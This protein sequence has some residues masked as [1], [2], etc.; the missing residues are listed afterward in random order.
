[1]PRQAQDRREEETLNTAGRFCR[2]QSLIFSFR[3]RY[4]PFMSTASFKSIQ[5][6]PMDTWEAAL[7][8]PA[9]KAQML[10]EITELMTADTRAGTLTKAQWE[11]SSARWEN[12]YPVVPDFIYE[13]SPEDSFAALALATGTPVLVRKR[14]IITASFSH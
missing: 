9:V 6:E 8:D 11:P 1:M 4:H 3:S 14:V 7:S 10:L 12:L 2:P 13:P 5:K